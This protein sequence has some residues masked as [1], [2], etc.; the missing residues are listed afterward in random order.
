LFRNSHTEKQKSPYI[1]GLTASDIFECHVKSEMS[2]LKR[3]I[4]LHSYGM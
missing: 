2:A 3:H 4:E 1:Q